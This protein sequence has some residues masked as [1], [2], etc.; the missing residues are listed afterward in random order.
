MDTLC[1][2]LQSKMSEV[3]DQSRMP[4][5][6]PRDRKQCE[7]VKYYQ[8]KTGRLSRDEIFS[9]IEFALQSGNFLRKFEIY[10]NLVI[11]LAHE[12]FLKEAKDIIKL[13]NAD[14]TLPQLVSYDTTFSMGD[15]YL[16]VLVC[17]NVKLEGDPIFPVAFMIH[18]RKFMLTHELFFRDILPTLGL[19]KSSNFPIVADREQ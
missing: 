18:E 5:D 4:T 8:N 17:R 13:S 3:P 19:A 14:V 16:S 10:P 6:R 15:F 2:K 7:N 9:S 12:D 11:T 1:N